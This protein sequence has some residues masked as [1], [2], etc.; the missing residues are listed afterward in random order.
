M[1]PEP[2]YLDRDGVLNENVPDYVRNLSMWVPI[3]G[4]LEAAAM[5]SGMG[6]PVVVVTNQSAIGRGLVD[7]S[8]VEEINSELV[9]RISLLGGRVSGVYYC[10]HRP[11]EHCGCRKPETGMIDRARRELGLPAGGWLVG[12]AESDMEMGRR[13]GLRT[14][15]VMT[16]RGSS[17][18][19]LSQEGKP[20]AFIAGDMADAAGIILDSG[21]CSRRSEELG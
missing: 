7:A 2:V 12:D 15:M 20:P 14:I 18:I 11:D 5:L 3:P 10:P 13:A 4:A 17:Q 9:R 16:G 19:A 8:T 21:R 1:A 6:H